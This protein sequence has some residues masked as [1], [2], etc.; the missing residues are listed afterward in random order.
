MATVRMFIKL[1]GTRDGA[2]WPNAG[3]TLDVSAEEA[4]QLVGTRLA[5]H[6]TAT[7]TTRSTSVETADA[8]RVADIE[9]ADAAPVKRRSR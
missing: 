4:D 6:V 9:T 1:S 3:D 2:D 7:R 8:V 5:E